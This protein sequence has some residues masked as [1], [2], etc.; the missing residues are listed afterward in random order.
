MCATMASRP[1]VMVIQGCQ[2]DDRTWDLE[3][4]GKSPS[5]SSSSGRAGNQD[6]GYGHGKP[7]KYKK[8]KGYKGGRHRDHGEYPPYEHGYRHPGHYRPPSVQGLIVDVLLRRVL[9]RR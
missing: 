9:H 6:L 5:S 3:C 2:H 7:W 1:D 8:W 4:S